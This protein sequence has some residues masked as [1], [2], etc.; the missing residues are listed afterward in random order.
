MYIYIYINDLV[1]GYLVSVVPCS[2]F[3]KSWVEDSSSRNVSY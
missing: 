3:M 1:N 2:G